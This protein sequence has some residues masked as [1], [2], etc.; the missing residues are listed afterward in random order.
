MW[1]REEPSKNWLK[2]LVIPAHKKGNIKHSENYRGIHLLN[3]GCNIYT[4]IIKNKLY[5]LT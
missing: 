1:D 2:T 4:N 5:I 3:S